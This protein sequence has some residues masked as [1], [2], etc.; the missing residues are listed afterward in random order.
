MILDTGNSNEI[1]CVKTVRRR[2]DGEKSGSISLGT[3]IDSSFIHTHTKR[4][5]ESS[6]AFDRVDSDNRVKT[7][8]AVLRYKAFGH[9]KEQYPFDFENDV[10]GFRR[11]TFKNGCIVL[12]PMF[13]ENDY[14]TIPR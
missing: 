4:C 14:M 7:H 6:Q 8:Y 1:Y 12:E 2:R 5:M 10:V 13:K 11:I 9:P 3:G